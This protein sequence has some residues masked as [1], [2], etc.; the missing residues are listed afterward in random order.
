E[1]LADTLDPGRDAGRAA[2]V[3]HFRVD[4]LVQGALI[5]VGLV[6]VDEP[7]NQCLV[8]LGIHGP[9]LAAAARC[10]HR[11]TYPCSG[12][13]HRRACSIANSAALARLDTPILA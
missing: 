6:L 9:T 13:G 5:R 1:L 7:A 8:L 2:V 3:G 4:D 11:Q 10:P 12:A